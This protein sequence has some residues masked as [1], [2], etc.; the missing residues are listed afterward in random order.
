MRK[1]DLPQH[2]TAGL[3][4]RG[5]SNLVRYLSAKDGKTYVKLL[6]LA[7]CDLFKYHESTR[8]LIRCK[9]FWKTSGFIRIPYAPPIKNCENTLFSEISGDSV[10]RLYIALGHYQGTMK[11]F[12]GIRR[13]WW[14]PL[15]VIILPC[16]SC[17]CR[18][19]TPEYRNKI[20]EVWRRLW[21]L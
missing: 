14:I 15:N 19:L 9:K 10:F 18:I 13:L 16:L 20:A 21:D 11:N 5:I 7:S 6:K 4:H 17:T 1:K 2:F 12:W 3:M 8:V